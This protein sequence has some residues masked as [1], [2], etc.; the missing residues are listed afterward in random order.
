MRPFD[1]SFKWFLS[2]YVVLL[3]FYAVFQF[4]RVY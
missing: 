2:A 4:G 1:R 3:A